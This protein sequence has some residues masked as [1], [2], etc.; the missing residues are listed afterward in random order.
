MSRDDRKILL[1][2]VLFGLAVRILSLMMI[3]T[4]ADERDYW[5]SAKRLVLGFPYTPIQHRTVRFGIILPVALAQKLLGTHPNVY[6]VLP[7]LLS[8]LQV[9]FMFIL[10]LKLSGRAV[11]FLAA[12]FMAMFPYMI[13]AGSQVRPEIFSVTYILIGLFFFLSYLEQE[14]PAIISLCLSALFL[15]LAYMSKITSLY[16]YPGF[17]AAILLFKKRKGH[18]VLFSLLLAA[19]YL[20]ETWVLYRLSGNPLGNLGIIRASHLESGYIAPMDFWGLFQRYSPR[21]LPFY[22]LAVL[23]LFPVAAVFCRLWL[24]DRRIDTLSLYCLS[25]LAGITFAVSSLKPVMP[26]EAFIHRYFLAMLGPLLLVESIFIVAAAKK[27]RAALPMLH[28]HNAAGKGFRYGAALLAGALTIG[29]VF[30]LG[31]LPKSL[32]LYF[33]NP[34]RPEQHPLFLNVRYR[35]LVNQAYDRVIPFLSTNDTAGYNALAT[36]VSYFLDEKHFSRGELPQIREVSLGAQNY[37]LLLNPDLGA[38]APRW[39]A[40]AQRQVVAATRNP[41]HL[42]PTPLG[43]LLQIL[44]E[45][46]KGK[47]SNE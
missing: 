9:A 30:S 5:F 13:R 39:T 3:H 10:G 16:F 17:I 41:F 31:V 43:N 24:R 19:L 29:A 44:R 22:W 14:G 37:F 2:L 23:L 21:Y 15:F 34:L 28:K 32:S 33:N 42:S 27:A 25:F 47:E 11:G 6:Y 46:Q 35:S 26:V 8:A 7:L 20:G 4:G 12:V 40:D 18:A 36:C 38:Q 1:C 45:G